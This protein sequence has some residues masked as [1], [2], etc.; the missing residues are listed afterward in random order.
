M[1]GGVLGEYRPGPGRPWDAGAAAHQL[2]RAG[3]QPSAGEIAAGLERGPRATADGLV[4]GAPEG[5][6]ARELDEIAG[7]V[8]RA[9]NI[10]AA[11]GWWLKRMVRTSRPL[12]ARVSVFWH[13]HFATSNQKVMSAPLMMKQLE[14]I[15]RLGMGRFEDLL[16]G[17]SRDPAMI[18]WLDGDSN[19]KGRPN[20][21]Y[22]RELFELFSLGVGNYTEQDIKESARAFTGWHQREGEF[23]FFERDHDG[24]AKTVFGE[25][26]SFDGSDIVA[27][28]VKRPACARFLSVK[29]L[30]EFVC[31]EPSGELVEAF[32]GVLRE[33]D[34]HIGE[35]LRV[36]LSSGAM[37]EPR[38]R[39]ARIK[40]PVEFVVGI[41]RSLETKAPAQ[42]LV[43]SVNQM[44][45]RLLEPPSVKGWNG[46]RAWIN[47]STVLLR[48]TGV[49]RLTAPDGAG[50]LSVQELRSRHGLDDR[51]KVIEYCSRVTLDGQ[52]PAEVEGTL[53]GLGGGGGGDLDAL[54]RGALRVLMSTPE[55]QLA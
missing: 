8:N 7:A 35:S 21:N 10:D 42:V 31:P 44:G 23:R 19:I 30:R 37:F 4:D 6:R 11:R 3:F 38:V 14:T 22:A 25:T 40:S 43:S 53:A 39:R 12:R 55:Y 36:L 41:A 28:A 50:V 54:M 18:A 33:R 29:L 48:L 26:G 45:Q 1:S 47:S 27:M 20:E 52:V 32:A 49:E 46:H 13:N 16:L 15:E 51:A 17:M 34:L 9:E 24:S 2:R 5:S